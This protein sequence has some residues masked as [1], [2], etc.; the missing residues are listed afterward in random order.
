MGFLNRKYK[1]PQHYQPID[2]KGQKTIFYFMIGIIAITII[3][4]LSF[5][6]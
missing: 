1:T 2:K 4:I 3:Y 6:I 5:Y